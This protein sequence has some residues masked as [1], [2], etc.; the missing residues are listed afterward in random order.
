MTV[1]KQKVRLR[2][3]TSNKYGELSDLPE[4]LKEVRGLR[5]IWKPPIAEVG[6][7]TTI[8]GY[9]SLLSSSYYRVDKFLVTG[10]AQSY[11]MVWKKLRGT[12]TVWTVT[13]KVNENI[14][15]FSFDLNYGWLYARRLLNDECRLR[16]LWQSKID[17]RNIMHTLFRK[18]ITRM[19]APT[20]NQLADND[21]LLEAQLMLITSK[22]RIYRNLVRGVAPAPREIRRRVQEALA[23]L[24]PLK[25]EL[26]AFRPETEM[27]R[28]LKSE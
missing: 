24:A 7:W 22:Q 10:D 16:E 4:D 21:E 19:L 14:G 15:E 11:S 3:L 20:F 1:I 12:H 17:L 25:R 8:Y 28:I 18:E 26:A 5:F 27:T 6:I 9:W 23:T 13:L 2:I